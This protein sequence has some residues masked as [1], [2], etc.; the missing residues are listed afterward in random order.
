[1]R[2]AFYLVFTRRGGVRAVLGKHGRPRLAGNEFAVRLALEVPETVFDPRPVPD[3]SLTVPA[4]YVLEAPPVE[5]T[6]LGCCACLESPG[7]YDGLCDCSCHGRA[8]PAVLS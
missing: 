6:A 7:G 4:S 3:V 8:Q 2:I 5:V 1:M